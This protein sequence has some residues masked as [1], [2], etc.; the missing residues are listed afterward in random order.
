MQFHNSFWILR[1]AGA[2]LLLLG[3]FAAASYAADYFLVA[4]QYDKMLP[5]GEI[6]TMWGFAED[7]DSDLN[8]D[9]GEIPT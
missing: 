9:D 6:V 3:I 2:C 4:K 7:L 1:L 5:D 8:T